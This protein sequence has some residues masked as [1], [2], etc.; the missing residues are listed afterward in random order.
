G[1]IYLSIDLDG[2]D[3]AFA[4]GVSHREAGGL[5]ARE[6]IGLI[7][8]LPGPIAG[9]DIVEYNPSQDGCGITAPLCAK[10][11]K[12]VAARMIETQA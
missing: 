8:S 12:E 1:P 9:A 11:V 4:P 10:L 2:L 6:V 5:T 3:P 7:Q